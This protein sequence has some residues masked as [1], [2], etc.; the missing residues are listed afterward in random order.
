MVLVCYSSWKSDRCFPQQMAEGGVRWG[1]WGL[2]SAYQGA[3]Y[4]RLV[5]ATLPAPTCPAFLRGML[6]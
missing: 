6:S 5:T 4:S 2:I 3:H 1:A